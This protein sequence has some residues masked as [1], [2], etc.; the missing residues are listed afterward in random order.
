[1][2]FLWFFDPNDVIF[3]SFDRYS[4]TKE[5]SNSM[6]IHIFIENTFWCRGLLVL[7]GYTV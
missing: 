5:V 3:V 1:M 4:S 2:L 7:Q 6:S